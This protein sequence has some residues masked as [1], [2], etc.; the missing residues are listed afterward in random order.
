MNF[1]LIFIIGAFLFSFTLIDAAYAQIG[2]GQPAAVRSIDVTIEELDKIH[3]VH[4]VVQSN[5]GNIVRLI[6]GTVSNIQVVDENGNE[7]EHGVSGG[8]GDTTITLFPRSQDVFV[9]YDLNNVMFTKHGTTWTWNFL[10]LATTTFHLPES[11]PA[12]RRVA[13]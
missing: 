10:Y 5:S 4:E 1:K 12:C 8:F 6:E 11:T 9:K 7:V 13:T 2:I 3:V